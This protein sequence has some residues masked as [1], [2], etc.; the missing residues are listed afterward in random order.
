M[1]FIDIM[2]INSAWGRPVMSDQG[3]QLSKETTV[4]Q[5]AGAQIIEECPRIVRTLSDEPIRL[6]G[7]WTYEDV[8]I[9]DPGLRRYMCLKPMIL[10]HTEGRNQKRRFGKERMPIVERLMNAL[11]HPGKNAGKKHKVYGVV[12]R[13]FDIIY[14]ATGKNPLQVLVDAVV[15]SAP[16]EEVTRV[17]YGG[18]AYP[19][20]VDVTPARRLDIAI[21]WLAQ[22]ARE[23]A[24]NNPKPL[25][26]CLAEEI[27]AA[28]AGDL[29]SF[30]VKHRDD[31]ERVAASAR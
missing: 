21:R 31:A 22:G 12:K 17:I 15:N 3:Q 7:K 4:Y 1:G 9:R 27:I 29:K 16:R 8:V 18:I 19:V 20:A 13:S 28:A 23:C 11:L 30:A 24:H 26:E 2:F 5:V 25:E 10:P 14:L 6:F